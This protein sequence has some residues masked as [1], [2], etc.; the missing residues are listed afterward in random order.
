MQLQQQQLQQNNMVNAQ[1]EQV[2]QQNN[3]F[4]QLNVHDP[5]SAELTIG[6]IQHAQQVTQ[7]AQAQVQQTQAHAEHI[8]QLAQ[9]E[10]AR[11]SPCTGAHCTT[12]QLC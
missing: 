10:V 4:V 2:N 3:T 9:H 5:L 12:Y 8:A 1:Q 6:A 11:A 7:S